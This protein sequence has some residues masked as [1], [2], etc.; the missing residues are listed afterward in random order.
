MMTANIAV[1]PGVKATLPDVLI[2]WLCN[3]A[4]SEEDRKN[5][6]Q[7]FVL[8]L[9]KLGDYSVQNI[10]YA[11]KLR[12]LFGFPPVTFNLQV[13]HCNNQYQMVMAN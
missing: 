11:D 4:I 7:T 2:D 9:E 8:T 5:P 6:V 3:L 1:S 10:R 12:R 13:R